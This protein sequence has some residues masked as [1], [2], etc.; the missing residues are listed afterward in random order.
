MGKLDKRFCPHPGYFREGEEGEFPWSNTSSS[1][2][3]ALFVIEDGKICRYGFTPSKSSKICLLNS[4]KALDPNDEALL[5]GIW[6]G[7]R[8]TDL[9]VLDRERAVEELEKL[10]FGK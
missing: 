3:Y 10:Q 8:R 6:N 5:I 1:T 7:E 9:F 2:W 4:L